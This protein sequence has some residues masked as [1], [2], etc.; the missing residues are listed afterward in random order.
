[1]EVKPAIKN[2]SENS[3]LVLSVCLPAELDQEMEMKESVSW[4]GIAF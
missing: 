3:D 1:M 4:L 2:K